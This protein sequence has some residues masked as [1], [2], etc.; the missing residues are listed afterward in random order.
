MATPIAFHALIVTIR[1]VGR[2]QRSVSAIAGA[3]GVK[4]RDLPYDAPITDQ[5]QKDAIFALWAKRS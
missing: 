3:L 5:Q 4:P 2:P 1:P